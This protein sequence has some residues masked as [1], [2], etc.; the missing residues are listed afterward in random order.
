MSQSNSTTK[1]VL[2]SV[3][4]KIAELISPGPQSVD[5]VIKNVRHAFRNGVI[6]EDVSDTIRRVLHI[7]D[8]RVEDIMIPRAL[9]RTIDIDSSTEEILRDVTES[10]HSRFPVLGGHSDNE[11]QGVLLAKDILQY[12]RGDYDEE[13]NLHDNLRD[14]LE[15]H[16]L[17]RVS[18][19]I[20]LFQK[21][22]N[23]MAIV[24]DEY[25]GLAGLITLEDVLEEIVGE[26]EDE[27]DLI[28]TDMIEKRSDNE[29]IVHAHTEI[30]DFNQA[31]SVNIDEDTDTIGG[32][33]LKLAGRVPDVGEQFH[34]EGLQFEIDT[35]NQRKILTLRVTRV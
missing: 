33:V 10:G 31:F 24:V 30:G 13:F 25:N 2:D 23:H 20:D 29:H 11:V 6:E 32:V 5:E 28:E 14:A 35:A 19:L 27:S 4:R 18:K 7:S 17:M 3:R 9:M 15:V 26:I 8:L 22:R 12:H 34:H 16:E 1:K 21:T